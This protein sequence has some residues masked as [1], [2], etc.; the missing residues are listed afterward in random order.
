MPSQT[1]ASASVSAHLEA[2]KARHVA[3]S[4]KI[5]SEQ[6]RPGTSDWYLRALKQQK[7]FLKETI[8]EVAAKKAS[9]S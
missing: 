8:E 9:A 5:E 1:H 4:N 6:T 2:L 7:L 3:L